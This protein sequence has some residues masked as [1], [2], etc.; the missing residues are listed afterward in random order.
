MNTHV[1]AVLEWEPVDN[2]LFHTLRCG[3]FNYSQGHESLFFII[4]GNPGNM[5]FYKNFSEALFARTG[6]PVWG[7][8]HTGHA[9]RENLQII[10][11]KCSRFKT[12][13]PENC[14][15]SSQIEHKILFLKTK[16][17]PYCNKVYLIG[18][19]IGC[20]MLLHILDKLNSSQ[21]HA[22]ILLFPGIERLAI[23]P[24]GEKLTPFLTNCHKLVQI[25]T[26]MLAFVP[27]FLKKRLVNYLF[28]D[29]D[30]ECRSTILNHVI[31]PRV[32]NACIFL[33]MQE[34][35]QVHIRDD[36]I[37]N[38]HKDK[39][40]FYYGV[41]DGWCPISYYEDIKSA[42]ENLNARLCEKNYRHAFVLRDSEGMAD[43]VSDMLKENL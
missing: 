42:F 14:T 18:H 37:I 39:L 26:L 41:S 35:Q 24:Q 13:E 32:A 8:S 36:N 31:I 15:L 21:L 23:S 11:N 34:M 40:I 25:F 28:H 30:E 6:V 10:S 12:L 33:G 9:N 5:G 38:A 43:I 27:Y 17:L 1:M 2:V 29:V 4:P 16:V 7:V 22:G 3:F 20:Y 19:S